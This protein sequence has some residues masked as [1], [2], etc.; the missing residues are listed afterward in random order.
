MNT[1]IH[2]LFLI[3]GL[4]VSAVLIGEYR[5]VWDVLKGWRS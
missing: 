4:Y 1:L 5:K 2:A 3:V